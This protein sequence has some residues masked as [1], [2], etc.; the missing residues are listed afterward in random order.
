MS[1][2]QRK[3]KRE[4]GSQQVRPT[5]RKGIPPK[6]LELVKSLKMFDLD[7]ASWLNFGISANITKVFEDGPW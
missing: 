3:K 1:I 7:F 6:P 4:A 5:F 2:C